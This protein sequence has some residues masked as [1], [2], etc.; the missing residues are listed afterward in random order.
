MSVA[1][2]LVLIFILFASLLTFPD[3]P[4]GQEGILVNLGLPDVGQGDENAPPAAVAEPVPQPQPEVTPPPTPTPTRPEPVKEREVR[5]TED[6]EAAALRRKQEADRK[7]QAEADAKRRAEED[8]KRRAEEDARRKAAEEAA[9]QKAEADRLKGEVGGLFGGGSGRGNTGTSGNQGDP[10]G[11]PNAGNLSGVS[12][13]IGT[14]GGGLG[15]RNV[16]SAPRITDTSQ[17]RGSVVV[18]VCVDASGNVTS[19]AFTQQG[20]TATSARLKDLAVSNARTW[21]F[22]PGADNQCGTITYNFQVR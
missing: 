19:A 10:S 8:A 12:T 17:D 16:V 6:P 3:P 1:I 14:V 15:G 7:A 20:S 21:K 4:P 5:T 22:G 13:G 11:D 9:R 18:R 2:H